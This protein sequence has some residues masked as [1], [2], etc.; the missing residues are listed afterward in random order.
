MLLDLH[1]AMKLKIKEKDIVCHGSPTSH[2]YQ[3]FPPK[4]NWEKQKQNTKQ[5][6]QTN[7][8]GPQPQTAVQ[9]PKNKQNDLIACFNTMEY[10]G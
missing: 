6:K 4:S 3:H 5:N 8:K 2:S 10:E 9:E 7:K 1:N